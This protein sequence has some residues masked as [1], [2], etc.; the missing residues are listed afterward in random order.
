[1]S[2]EKRYSFSRIFQKK[3]KKGRLYRDPIRKI[4]A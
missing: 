2:K 1:M 4:F 3:Q